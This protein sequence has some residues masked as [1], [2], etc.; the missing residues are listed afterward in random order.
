MKVMLT[1]LG[2]LIVSLTGQAQVPS[3]D[4]ILINLNLVPSG[5]EAYETFEKVIKHAQEHEGLLS[6]KRSDGVL[7]PWGPANYEEVVE[8]R[9]KSMEMMVDWSDKLRQDIPDEERAKMV[10]LEVLFYNYKKED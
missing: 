4:Q 6:V 5:F 1:I 3:D 2:L 9:W 7:T 10:G 8:F